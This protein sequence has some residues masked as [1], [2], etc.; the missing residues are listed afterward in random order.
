MSK[1][2][3]KFDEF[4]EEN[5]PKLAS[6]STLKMKKNL[7]PEIWSENKHLFPSVRTRLLKIAQDFVDKLKL[8]HLYP[9]D[10]TFTGSLANYNWS[11]YSD[12]DLHI[13]IDFRSTGQSEELMR[14]LIDAKR[15]EWNRT[16]DIRVFGYEVEIYVQDKREPHISTGVYSVMKDSWILKPRPQELDVDWEEVKRKAEFIAR[17]V[18]D[19]YELFKYKKYREAYRASNKLKVKLRK[20]R[21]C[22]LE[23]GGQ[24]STENLAFKLLRRSDYLGKLSSLKVT[25]YDKM[26]SMGA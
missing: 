11:E 5:D 19:V 22:G 4:V 16:H 8:N 13:I 17:R 24:Y 10:V 1:L 25:S 3:E 21:K 18:E 9:Y 23:H 14:E 26:M 6:T 12:I 15:A 2:L 20:F 7:N